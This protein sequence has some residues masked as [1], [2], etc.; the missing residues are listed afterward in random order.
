MNAIILVSKN[1]VC[2]PMVKKNKDY[3]HFFL[4]NIITQNIFNGKRFTEISLCCN[5]KGIL[6]LRKESRSGSHIDLTLKL[7]SE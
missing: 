1:E 7:R 6:T 3:S 5:M 2:L 4:I